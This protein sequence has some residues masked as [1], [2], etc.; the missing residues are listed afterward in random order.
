V[1]VGNSVTLSGSQSS[2]L[3]LDPLGAVFSI[4]RDLRLRASLWRVVDRTR[5]PA[6]SGIDVAIYAVYDRVDWATADDLAERAPTVIISSVKSHEDAT[7]A[8][9]HGLT[10]Y[11]DS[12]LPI[13]ALR[14]ALGGVLRGEPAYSRDVTGAWLRARRAAALNASRDIG[15]TPRQRQIV[16]LIARGATDKEIAGLLG[17]ATATAQKHVTNILERLQVPNRAAAVAVVSARAAG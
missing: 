10:G 7:E 12:S 8:L 1:V 13:D 15:L 2:I 3:V 4:L 11:L 6:L 5:I 14:R 9:G 17:I 16:A